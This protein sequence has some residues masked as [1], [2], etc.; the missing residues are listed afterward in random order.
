MQKKKSLCAEFCSCRAAE[1]GSRVF[2]IMIE[3]TN[4]LQNSKGMLGKPQ[5]THEIKGKH[6]VRV[7]RALIP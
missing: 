6:G 2:W 4:F 1:E 5:P 3:F 7:C